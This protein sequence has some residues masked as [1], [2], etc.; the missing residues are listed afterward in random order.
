ARS[1]GL[2][3]RHSY[4]QTEATLANKVYNYPAACDPTDELVAL[5]EETSILHVNNV[6][7]VSNDS[8][9]SSTADDGNPVAVEFS[10]ED[11][12]WLEYMIS[13]IVC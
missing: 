2:C 7:D 9:C 1:A 11:C 4:V 3:C 6:I 10:N 8:D 12:D 13:N 5:L